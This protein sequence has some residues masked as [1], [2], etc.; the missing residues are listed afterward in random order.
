MGTFS[1]IFYASFEISNEDIILQSHVPDPTTLYIYVGLFKLGMHAGDL[2]KYTWC[3]LDKLTHVI[4]FK[5][6]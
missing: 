3:L 2:H 1:L 5:R 6:L 4:Y